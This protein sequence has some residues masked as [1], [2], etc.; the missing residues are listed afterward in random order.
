MTRVDIMKT[1]LTAFSFQGLL[2]L[3]GSLSVAAP[4]RAS[5]SSINVNA[6]GASVV[7]LTFGPLTSQAPAE[8][9]WCGDVIPAAPDVGSKCN[10][11]TTWGC[12]P[13]RLDLS[14]TSVGGGFTDIL[15]IPNSVAMRA[16]R[17]AETGAASSYFYVRRFRNTQGGPDEYVAVTCLTMAADSARLR[18]GTTGPS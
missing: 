8:A 3:S 6:N 4:I 10:P 2:L 13:S 1:S 15:T 14:A 16:Y 7:F 9:C 18:L 17:A 11:A 5:P 12:L